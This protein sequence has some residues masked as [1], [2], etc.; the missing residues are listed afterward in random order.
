M[1]YPVNIFLLY[2]KQYQYL[3]GPYLR[4]LQ[5]LWP[6]PLKLQYVTK[7]FYTETV[8]MLWQYGVRI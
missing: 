8:T 7:Y 6:S 3:T 4:M 2:E 1:F 5:Y